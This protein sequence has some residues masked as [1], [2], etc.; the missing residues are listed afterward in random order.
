MGGFSLKFLKRIPK[1]ILISL[2]PMFVLGFFLGSVPGYQFYEY[3][4]KDANFC[5]SCHVHDYASVGWQD[6]S[7]G[8]KTTCHDCHHQPLHQY[9]EEAVILVTKNPKFPKDLDHVPYIPSKLCQACHLGEGQDLSTITGPMSPE[10]IAKAPKVDK[11]RLHRFHLE[12]KTTLKLLKEHKLSKK[13]KNADAPVMPKNEY[14]KER[15]VTCSDCHGG[16]ANRGHNFNAVDLSCIRCHQDSHKSGIGLKYGCRNC[17][18]QEFLTPHSSGA[19]ESGS[20]VK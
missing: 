6:S 17:H 9:F 1:P 16:P 13:E 14:G 12:Q 15:L 11:T 3:T 19:I 10:E 4:W 20:K 5:T 8:D 18:M 7:H 2:L